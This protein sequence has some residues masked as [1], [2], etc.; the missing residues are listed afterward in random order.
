MTSVL[1]GH[2]HWNLVARKFK[3]IDRRSAG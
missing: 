1:Q 2:E 3:D